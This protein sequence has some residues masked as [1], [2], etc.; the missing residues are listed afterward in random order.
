MS[1]KTIYCINDKLCEGHR[2]VAKSVTEGGGS[3]DLGGYGDGKCT[4]SVIG[5]L[6]E[7]KL[8]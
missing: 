5:I 4:V 7:M 6:K 8:R 3:S 1:A 2:R